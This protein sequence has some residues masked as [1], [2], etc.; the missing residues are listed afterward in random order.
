MRKTNRS[1]VRVNDLAREQIIVRKQRYLIK[2][3]SE[4][5]TDGITI[6]CSLVIG[7][8]LAALAKLQF[9]LTFFDNFSAVQL[10]LSFF[11]GKKAYN[12]NRESLD[13]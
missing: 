2:I 3:V 5:L 9:C 4:Q 10:V 12:N 11:I 6:Y 13:G 7:R 8:S 1:K